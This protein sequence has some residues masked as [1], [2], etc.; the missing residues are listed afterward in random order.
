M[1]VIG[2]VRV[3]AAAGRDRLGALAL[4]VTEDA[5]R[6]HRERLTLA[7]ILQVDANEVEELFQA[8]CRCNFRRLMDHA[9]HVSRNSLNGK[10]SGSSVRE[11]HD[12]KERT[13]K[14]RIH[15]WAA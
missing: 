4:S 5:E 1:N 15:S 7:P 6:V 3:R 8:G 13:A 11:R 12:G 14:A 10:V 2:L 9:R